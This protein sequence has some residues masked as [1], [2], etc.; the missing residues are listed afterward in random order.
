MDPFSLKGATGYATL[1]LTKTLGCSF[2]RV[3]KDRAL[4]GVQWRLPPKV[5]LQRVPME[6]SSDTHTGAHLTL[7]GYEDQKIH[8]PTSSLTIYEYYYNMITKLTSLS[9]A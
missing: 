4:H 7:W 5:L 3:G 6:P 1:L 9:L 2:S 8:C